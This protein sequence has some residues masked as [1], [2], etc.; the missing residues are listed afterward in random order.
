MIEKNNNNLL[1]IGTDAINQ[2]L[3]CLYPGAKPIQKVSV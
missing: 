2:A 3:S 1:A